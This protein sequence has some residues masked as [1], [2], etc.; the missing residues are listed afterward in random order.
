VSPRY[1]DWRTTAAMQREFPYEVE[2]ATPGLGFRQRLNLIENWVTAR[3]NRTD[4]G[5]WG[6]RRDMQDYAVWAF[7]DAETAVAFR[8]HLEWV[9]S[10]T[11]QQAISHAAKCIKLERS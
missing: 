8:R 2:A 1:K 9:M 6:R 7:R 11:D 5:R 4:Y 10:L 3:L